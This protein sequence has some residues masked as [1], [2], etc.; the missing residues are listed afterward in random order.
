MFITFL[1]AAETVT[2]SNFLLETKNETVMID[3]GLFQGLKEL[4]LRNREIPDVDFNKLKNIII[5]HAHLDHTGYL[6]AM[7]KAGF[8]G[9]IHL[10][11]PTATLAALV[12]KDSAK[13]QEEEA[14]NANKEGY[15][16]HLPATPLYTLEDAE[17]AISMFEIHQEN[18]VYSIGDINFKFRFNGH[19]LGSS[20]VEIQA[21]GK[22]IIFSGDIGRN[23]SLYLDP[24][25]VPDDADYL[26]L[27]STYGNKNH[28]E[29]DPE[30]ELASIIAEADRKKGNL[31]IASFSIGRAQEL[32]LLINRLRKSNK[33][34][35]LPIVFDS[36]MG[37]EATAALFEF[38]EWQKLDPEHF[39]ELNNDVF[40][41][42]GLDET[43]DII[44]RVNQKIII[45]GSGMV[46]GGRILH[47]LKE[48]IQDKRHTLL[49]VGYQG[50][51]TRGRALI[52]GAQEIKFFGKYY[53]VNIN[54]VQMESLSAHADQQ[55]LLDWVKG[56]KKKPQK[57]FLVHGEIQ[58]MEVL[59]DKLAQMNINAFIPKHSER[60]EI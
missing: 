33:I 2:G 35:K 34:P 46:T 23:H 31:L 60:I 12:L 42:K 39:V 28:P 32:L 10:T 21:E 6:P 51:G 15:S 9:K 47:Y 18:Q 25:T 17:A 7:V 56:F 59:K 19:I 53:P 27:E 55:E 13:I 36:P 24:P 50:E 57:I 1:G 41:V 4:R 29:I 52:D 48:Y 54:I 16:K 22:K 11:G 5:T 43:Y 26:I 3:C 8:K 49:L 45:A 14:E 30:T 37:T 20:Y 38:P 40:Y 44:H 58:A